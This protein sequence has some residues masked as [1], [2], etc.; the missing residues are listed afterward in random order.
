MADD[1]APPRSPP[2]ATGTGRP[3]M[4]PAARNA[5]ASVLVLVAI[6]GLVFTVRLAVTGD[7]NT[8]D[9]LPDSVDRLIP[10]SGD[11]VLA[12]SSVG[13]DLAV[14]FDAY[15]I[16]NGTEIRTEADGLTKDLG[17]GLVTFQPG[18]GK[19]VDTLLPEKNC[20]IAMVWPQ[21]EGED[22]AEPVSWCFNAA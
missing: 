16:V 4:Q 19:P 17:L 3:P 7:D 15:L 20:V 13:V 2:A 9:A 18:N 22:S 5:I 6:V 21:T 11:E 8:S 14:G 12:Q 1:Q 10:D